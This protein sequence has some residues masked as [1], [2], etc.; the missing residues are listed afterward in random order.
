[1]ESNLTLHIVVY[2]DHLGFEQDVVMLQVDPKDAAD[3][4]R[5]VRDVLTDGYATVASEV[6]RRLVFPPKNRLMLKLPKVGVVS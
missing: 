6:E 5:N 2:Y 3:L 1:M 4:R